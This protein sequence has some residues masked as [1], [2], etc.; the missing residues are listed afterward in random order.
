MR[1]QVGIT[2]QLLDIDTVLFSIGQASPDKCLEKE[3]SYK[4]LKE[5]ILVHQWEPEEPKPLL[6]RAKPPSQKV[7]SLPKSIRQSREDKGQQ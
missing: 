6:A 2:G 1:Q 3:V 7:Y 4:R 5:I